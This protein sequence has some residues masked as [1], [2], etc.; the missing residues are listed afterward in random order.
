MAQVE[1]DYKAQIL[2]ALQE[3]RDALDRI[4]E[5]VADEKKQERT[6]RKAKKRTEE[7]K[8]SRAKLTPGHVLKKIENY[9]E[10]LY[11][12][13]KQVK[14]FPSGDLLVTFEKLNKEEYREFKDM[15]EKLFN[16]RYSPK[17]RGFVIKQ[18]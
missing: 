12:L 9:D 10:N 11:E 17:Y 13:V 5:A 14:A 7:K 2:A 1:I 4:A 15:M 6:T 8:I 3:I 18:S 16:A